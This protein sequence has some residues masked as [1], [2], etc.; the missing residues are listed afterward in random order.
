MTAILIECDSEA[1]TCQFAIF[2]LCDANHKQ[3]RLCI[4]LVP[5]ARQSD[6]KVAPAKH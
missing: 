2:R 6:R 5:N 4:L 1:L 3:Q